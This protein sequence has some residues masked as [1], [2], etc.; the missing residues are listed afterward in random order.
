M[1]VVWTP[2]LSGYRW[3]PTRS[4]LMRVER[5]NPVTVRHCCGGGGRPDR[6]EGGI[7]S[8]NRTPKKRMP[9]AERQQESGDRTTWLLRRV[10][11]I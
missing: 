3:H 10:V 1:T 2:P 9:V 8:G 6:K 4:Y 7:P 11:V 5:G